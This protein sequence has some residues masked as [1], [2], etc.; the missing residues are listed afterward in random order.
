[1]PPRRAV[2]GHPARRNVDPP[3]QGVPNAPEV[4]PQGEVTNTEFRDSIWMLSQFVTNQVGQQIGNRQ[5]VADTSMIREFLRMNPPDF[6]GSSVTEDLENFVEELLKVLEVMHVGD[7]E[8]F[9]LVA[10]QLKGVAREVEEDKLRDRE[11]FWNKKAKAT[12]TEFGQ[13]KTENANR[14]SYQ[15]RP[16]GP[17]PSSASSLAPRNRGE[18]KN[19]NSQNFRARLAQSQSSVA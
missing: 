19:Q 4:Q 13:Q 18:F 12:G 17:S 6:T 8:R 15:Q 7:F 14:S 3:D 11:E 10:Y 5:D 16:T 2:Q 1:M 9:E